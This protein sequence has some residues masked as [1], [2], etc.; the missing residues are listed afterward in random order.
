MRTRPMKNTTAYQCR[1]CP[2]SKLYGK[3]PIVI[4]HRTQMHPHLPWY[5]YR[6]VAI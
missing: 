5:D 2:T 1:D 6:R 4:E 3:E